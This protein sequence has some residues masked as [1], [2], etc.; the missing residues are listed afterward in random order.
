MPGTGP[1]MSATLAN[2]IVSSL[3]PVWL[4]KPVQSIRV[5]PPFG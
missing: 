1:E 2:V 4:W 5:T 3:I